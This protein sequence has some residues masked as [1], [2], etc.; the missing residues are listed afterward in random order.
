MSMTPRFTFAAVGHN[1]ADTLPIALGHA[2]DAAEPGDHVWFV[3]SGSDDGSAKIARAHGA[4]V[5]TA[6]LG[7]GRAMAT[8]IDR[9]DDDFICFFDADMLETEHNI[10]RLLREAAV[11]SEIDML[12]GAY[13]EPDR[14]RTVTPAIYFPLVGALF[15]EVLRE[16]IV[17]PFSGFRVLRV[18]MPLGPLPP[19]YGVESALNV[20]MTMMD[21]QIASCPVGWFR[22]NLRNYVNSP[23]IATDVA[24]TLLDLGEEHGRL[25]RTARP[26][27]EAWVTEAVDLISEQPPP[28]ADDRAYLEDLARVSTRALPSPR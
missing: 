11:A 24:T 14:R 20:Q 12:V 2:H 18:E 21:A 7:K 22:G 6:P 26:E 28:G 15:P 5:V 3:D 10:P 16:D 9:C 13:D 4:S 8:A 25:A 27:W 19:G 1:E 23:A 17:V